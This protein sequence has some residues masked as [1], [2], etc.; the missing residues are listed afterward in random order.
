MRLIAALRGSGGFTLAEV[1]VAL[2][3]LSV[4]M[5]AIVALLLD[6]L[7]GSRHARE[8]TQAVDLAADIAERMRANR[9]GGVAYDTTDG[10]PAPRLDA[11]CERADAGCDPQAMAGNDLRRWLDSVEATLPDAAGS[12]AVVPQA[13]ALLRCTIAVTWTQ[14]G[15]DSRA[16]YRL[17]VDL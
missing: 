6:G 8:H 7:R 17:A 11:A 16:T 1:L 12:V 5:L 3:V 4:G 9:A 15:D 13:D 14:S 2:V 10:T